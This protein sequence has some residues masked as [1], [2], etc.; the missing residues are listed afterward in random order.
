MSGVIK[1]ITKY[2]KSFLIFVEIK[3]SSGQKKIIKLYNSFETKKFYPINKKKAKINLN[4]DKNKK[5]I[6]FGANNASAKYKGLKYFV[7]S[8]HIKKNLLTQ[9]KDI[10]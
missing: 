2:F 5:L 3:I 4:F 1:S 8:K 9:F 10:D 7:V 6:L